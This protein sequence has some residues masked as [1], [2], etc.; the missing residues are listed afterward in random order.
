MNTVI[1]LTKREKSFLGVALQAIQV[2]GPVVATRYDED[3]GVWV[4]QTSEDPLAVHLH[5]LAA[6]VAQTLHAALNRR[7]PKELFGIRWAW[8]TDRSAGE[9]HIDEG[10]ASLLQNI[11][12][13]AFQRGVVRVGAPSLDD[14]AQAETGEAPG[15]EA[16]TQAVERIK[17]DGQELRQLIRKINDAL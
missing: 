11:L 5:C 9:L 6:T 1:E 2:G 12:G 10:A 3:A 14:A 8:N 15:T 7:T 4:T 17:R 13:I 16:H